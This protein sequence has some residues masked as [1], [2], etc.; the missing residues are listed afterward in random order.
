MAGEQSGAQCFFAQG[1]VLQPVL[2]HAATKALLDR[3]FEAF[4]DDPTRG[5][6]VEATVRALN[7]SLEQVSMRI[8]SVTEDNGESFYAFVREK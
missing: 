3:A 8:V 2:S 5:R 1:F 4:P 7:E 6:G